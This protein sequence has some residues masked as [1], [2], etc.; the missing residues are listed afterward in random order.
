M[1]AEHYNRILRILEKGIPVE[2][3]MEIKKCVM[4]SFPASDI[5]YGKERPNAAATDLE[6]LGFPDD[7][8]GAIDGEQD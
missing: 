2:L 8:A 6:Y 3:E 7:T 1:A 5:R 4:R